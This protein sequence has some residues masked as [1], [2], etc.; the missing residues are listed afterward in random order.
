M[1]KYLSNFTLKQIQKFF[2]FLKIYSTY[3]FFDYFKQYSKDGKITK[4]IIGCPLNVSKSI[5]TE[6]KKT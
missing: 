4:K 2:E 1:E 5:S 3:C 6:S